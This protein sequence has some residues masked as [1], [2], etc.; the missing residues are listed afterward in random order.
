MMSTDL[1][2]PDRLMKKA[3]HFKE[4]ANGGAQATVRLVSGEIF[5]AV[6]VSNGAKIIAVRGYSEAPFSAA[7]IEDIHQTL[8]D[9][10]PA[11]RGSWEF[12]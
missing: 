8:T 1:R 9:E 12:F 5:E 4:F 7:D 6:L 10:C 11:K 3:V 2:L